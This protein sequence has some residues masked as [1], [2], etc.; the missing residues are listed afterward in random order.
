[1]TETKTELKTWVHWLAFGLGSGL[2]KKAPGT[3]GTLASVPVW[4]LLLQ[5]LALLPYL[6]V[7][8]V[9]SVLGVYLCGKTAHDM[10]LHDHPGIVWDEWIGFWITCIALPAGWPWVIAAFALFRFFDIIKPWPIR[11]LDAQ[12]HGGFGIMI[13]DIIAGLMALGVIQLAA[14]WIG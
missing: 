8:V 14:W 10:N 9:G 4:W 5:D 1:M 11:W 12:V 7:I 13:D 6:A 2:P 3:W